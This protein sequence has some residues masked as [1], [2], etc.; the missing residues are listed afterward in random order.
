[1]QAAQFESLSMALADNSIAWASKHWHGVQQLVF[2]LDN[3]DQDSAQHW[4]A[5]WR[6]AGH[7]KLHALEE[8]QVWGP[9][10]LGELTPFLCA[11]FGALVHACRLQRLVLSLGGLHALPSMT[12][13]NLKVLVLEVGK[14]TFYKGPEHELE[15]LSDLVASLEGLHALESLHLRAIMDADIA[16]DEYSVATVPGSAPVFR[17]TFPIVDMDLSNCMRL[18]R[19]TLLHVMPKEL[20][21][22]EGCLVKIRGQA[23]YLLPCPTPTPYPFNY[24]L[25]SA[26]GRLHDA[27]LLLSEDYTTAFMLRLQPL[28]N[29]CFCP[30]LTIL[31]LKTESWD[32]C[33]SIGRP[34]HP[35]RFA[36]QV[37]KLRHLAM[38]CADIYVEFGAACSLESLVI[39]AEFPDTVSIIALDV[40]SLTHSLHFFHMNL[41]YSDAD[42][43]AE[44]SF[45]GQVADAVST[46]CPMHRHWGM[47]VNEM[48]L[49]QAYFPA[50][51]DLPF[52]WPEG[53]QCLTCPGC[54]RR[55]G[56]LKF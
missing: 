33:A 32:N 43:S 14:F 16:D 3:L 1:M 4:K 8:L 27:D 50:A 9:Q 56:A 21:L 34:D 11:I 42:D 2:H 12:L 38:S 39:S 31:R 10:G 44:H 6:S 13:V 20:G 5:I 37:P 47:A 24:W 48:R 52:R 54:L 41:R 22:P 30:N 46:R 35:L 23:S 45:V 7:G 15:Y 26:F 17:H 29:A 18:K 19:V 53:C 25:W 49:F 51:A 55:K 40:G 36:E 28:L